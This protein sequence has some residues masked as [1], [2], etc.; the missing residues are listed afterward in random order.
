MG[1]LD[2]RRGDLWLEIDEWKVL[3]YK[4]FVHPTLNE[5]LRSC[6]DLLRRIAA[7]REWL[8]RHQHSQ[9]QAL[10]VGRAGSWSNAFSSTQLDTRHATSSSLTATLSEL[11]S[12]LPSSSIRSVPWNAVELNV[13]APP[14]NTY[15]P[16][17]QRQNDIWPSSSSS[18]TAS[19]PTRASSQAGS[20][21]SSAISPLVTMSALD[22]EHAGRDAHIRPGSRRVVGEQE[23][24]DT[25]SRDGTCSSSTSAPPATDI[26]LDSAPTRWSV[27]V[28]SPNAEEAD[29]T[30]ST[31]T[32]S[33][34]SSGT[35][36]PVARLAPEVERTSAQGLALGATIAEGRQIRASGVEIST[37]ILRR[38][39]RQTEEEDSDLRPKLGKGED[40]SDIWLTGPD[41][42]FKCPNVYFLVELHVRIRHGED[43]TAE[44]G[45]R[46]VEQIKNLGPNQDLTCWKDYP[47]YRA[48]SRQ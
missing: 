6:S 14:S 17:M 9:S 29:G 37:G 30:I 31:E 18:T 42:G 44:Y 7:V 16:R 48:P 2:R 22:P 21:S 8:R 43:L 10:S 3:G 38:A 36:S 45:A 19:E 27:Q 23:A 5:L 20:C 1:R 34:S 13:L 32:D 4:R 47:W 40:G 33:S 25:L 12:T 41:K 26:A 15:H 24:G 28:Q 11:S 35:A 46:Q 39:R